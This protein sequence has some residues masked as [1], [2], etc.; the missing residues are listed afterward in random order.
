MYPDEFI[1]IAEEN[2]IDFSDW[3]V[4]LETACKDFQ[5]WQRQS[6]K[7][8]RL[9]INL[10]ARQFVEQD[11]IGLLTLVS[12]Y[13]LDPRALELEITE[14]TAM[15]NSEQTGEIL[16]ELRG[17]GMKI[18]LDDFRTGYSSLSYL[19]RLP[20]HVLKIDKSFVKDI[21][22]TPDAASIAKTIV[23]MAHTLGLKVLAEGVENLEQMEMLKAF[24]CDEMQGFLFSRPV[25]PTEIGDMLRGEKT[26]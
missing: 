9:A 6:E 20:C 16:E 18:A 11:I 24:G 3:S 8:I 13:K 26:L 2:R 22:K 23:A 15:I 19:Q 7:S 21:A 1:P 5:S 17:L 10:S 25:S 14:T 12:E 4:G